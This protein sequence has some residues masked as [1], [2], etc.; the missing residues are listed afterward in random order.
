M[1]FSSS[2][3]MEVNLVKSSLMF[4]TSTINRE[5]LTGILGFLE[6]HLLL[7]YLSIP[8]VGRDLRCS[9]CV[10]LIDKM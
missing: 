6:N 10:S 2:I 7:K 5:E 3:G 4:S 9:Y 1:D 8:I